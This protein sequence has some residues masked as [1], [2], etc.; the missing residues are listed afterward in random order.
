MIVDH[1]DRILRL[2]F[3]FL[4][5]FL[6]TKKILFPAYFV[7]HA[8]LSD[9]NFSNYWKDQRAYANTYTVLLI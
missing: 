3:G 1:L 2:Y 5:L 6:E 7:N 8:S 9:L 4:L